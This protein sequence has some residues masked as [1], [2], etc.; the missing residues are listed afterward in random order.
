MLAY[1]VGWHLRRKLA[2]LLFEDSEREAAA[3]QRA[4]PVAP[5]EVAA[6]KVTS[7]RTPEGL[8]VQSLRTR[9]EHLGTLTLN[10][11]ILTP[12]D[13]QEFELLGVDPERVASSKLTV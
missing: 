8:P 9:L 11:V 3:A 2:P 5:A 13:P 12:D 7:K 4:S 6:S 1:Y 10:R